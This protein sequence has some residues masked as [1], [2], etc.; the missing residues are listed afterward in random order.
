VR[1]FEG[2]QAGAGL[3]YRFEGGS[4]CN[5]SIDGYRERPLRSDFGKIDLKGG[6]RR[7]A[8]TT[9]RSS[10]RAVIPRRSICEDRSDILA[11]F[12]KRPSLRTNIRSATSVAINH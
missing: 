10:G 11:A 5:P 7:L 4:E 3:A 9:R 12:K 8:I 1:W 6:T 2:A